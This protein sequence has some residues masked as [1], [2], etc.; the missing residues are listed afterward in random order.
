MLA[1]LK[2]PRIFTPL[3]LLSAAGFAFSGLH[4]T[5]PLFFTVD[6]FVLFGSEGVALDDGVQISSGDIGSNKEL[7]VKENGMVN[8]NLFADKITLSASTTISGNASYNTLKINKTAQILGVTTTPV[9]LPIANLPLFSDI[10]SATQDITITGTSTTLTAGNY[11]NITISGSSTLTLS[12]GIYN[13][14]SLELK[15]NSTLI[16]TASTTMNIQRALKGGKNISI[17][18]GLNLTPDQLTINYRGFTLKS[19]NN[20]HDQWDEDNDALSSFESDQERNDEQSGKIGH[21]AIFGDNAF[22][23]FRLI[24]PLANVTIGKGS[25]L[26]GQVIVRRV[27]VGRGAVVSREDIFAT[28]PDKTKVVTEGNMHFLSNEI[29]LLLAG[30]GT[31]S[32][33]RIIARSVN[34]RISGNIPEINLYKIEVNTETSAELQSLVQGILNTNNPLILG[35]TLNFLME[36]Q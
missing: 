28:T 9:Q 16:Y 12:G 3:L 8:G 36:T 19:D 35:V 31:P 18:N 6:K 22:L 25:V 24:A 34:G 26:R 15:D 13:T 29:V 20:T 1:L 17:L 10:T 27:R 33:A 11:R 14:R 5:P 32:D 21:P 2:N 23:N 7:T 4:T 30:G